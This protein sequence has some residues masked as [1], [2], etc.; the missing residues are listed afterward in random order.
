MILEFRLFKQSTKILVKVK[1]VYV[2]AGVARC[3]RKSPIT[4]AFLEIVLN[5]NLLRVGYTSHFSNH[6]HFNLSRILHVFLNLLRDI[7][8]K[9]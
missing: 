2:P 4:E 8:A 3:K 6:R 5:K 9:L 1:L 7:E